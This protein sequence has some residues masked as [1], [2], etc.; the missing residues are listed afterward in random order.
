MVPSSVITYPRVI[1]RYEDPPTGLPSPYAAQHI[2]GSL[3]F[4][5][6]SQTPSRRGWSLYRSWVEEQRQRNV[7][8]GLEDLTLGKV[9]GKTLTQSCLFSLSPGIWLTDAVIQASIQSILRLHPLEPSVSFLPHFFFTKLMNEGHAN[10][11]IEGRY[12]YNNVQNWVKR[13]FEG[14]KVSDMST[15]R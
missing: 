8:E 15:L 7:E 13:K 2:G 1:D 6:F 12:D 5:P 10:P 14:K 9:E 11:D 4:V 3:P